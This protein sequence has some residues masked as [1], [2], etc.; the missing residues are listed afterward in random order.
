M[1]FLTTDRK[2]KKKGADPEW[3]HPDDPDAQIT[4]MKSSAE[5]FVEG[6][7]EGSAHVAEGDG[8]VGDSGEGATKCAR[9][10]AVAPVNV[11]RII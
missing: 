4:K 5:I 3:M 6:T 9:A 10:P 2:R 7:R 11:S 8:A 1:N